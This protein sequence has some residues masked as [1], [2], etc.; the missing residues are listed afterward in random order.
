MGPVRTVRG[1]IVTALTLGVTTLVGFALAVPA[2]AATVVPT[3][4]TT[5]ASTYQTNGIVWALAYAN[6]VVYA[7]GTFTTVR[8][9]GAPQGA[10]GASRK[11][12]A[13]FNATTG[14]LLPCAPVA[15]NNLGNSTVRALAA[16]ADGGT[17]YVGGYFSSFGGVGRSNLAALN[18]AGCT[19]K[20]AFAPRVNSTVRAVAVNSGSNVYFGG[21]FHSVNGVTRNLVA[22]VTPAGA[23][24]SFNP[25]AVAGG[26][27]QRYTSMRALTVTA[28]NQQVVL[29]GDFVSVGGRAAQRLAMVNASTGTVTHT[30]GSFIPSTSTVKALAH[31]YSRFYLGAEGTGGGVFDGRAAFTSSTGTQVWRDNCLGATQAV[32]VA[33]QTL[34]SGS[35]AHDCSSTP[36]GFPNG[37]R[38]HLLAQAISDRTIQT[39]RPNTNDGIGEALGPRALTMSADGA[40]WVGG[41]FTTVNNVAQQGIT[42]FLPR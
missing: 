21:Q 2:E 3:V 18:T 10:A 36:G 33:G 19:V 34:Y 22:S 39:W 4:R 37:R 20:A 29:G 7:G 12:F 28:D 42:R 32:L 41:E 5:A 24:T 13:A 8:S 14:A 38:Y 25:N 6:G 31:D 16:S 17:L 30:F 9:P 26:D 11:N 35:H 15:T 1:P 40:L 27:P 23:L